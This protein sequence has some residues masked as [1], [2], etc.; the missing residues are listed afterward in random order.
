MTSRALRALVPAILS[1]LVTL[2]IAVAPAHAASGRFTALVVSMDPATASGDTTVTLGV[3]LANSTADAVTGI[4][5]RFLISNAPLQGRSEIP[6]AASGR[7]VPTFRT[8]STAVASG[9]DLTSGASTTLRLRTTTRALG[10][11]GTQS[12]VY[13]IGA[14]INGTTPAGPVSLRAVTLLPWMSGRATGSLGVAAFWTLTAPPSRDL[15]GVFIDDSLARAVEP[16]GR[17]RAQLD[18]IDAMQHTTL[19][20]DPLLVES[21]HSLA[22]GA[23]IR[24]DSGDVRATTDAEMRAAQQWLTDL[25]AATAQNALAALPVGDLDVAAALRYGRL[26]VARHALANA[27]QRLASALGV[28]RMPLI[29]PVHGGALPDSLWRTIA[30]FGATAVLAPGAGYPATQQR[31]TPSSAL[32]LPALGRP[33]LVVDAAASEAPV[34]PGL[35]AVQARQ[36][37]ASHLL[38]AYLEHPNDDR[39]IA[40]SV[41]PTWVPEA[42]GTDTAV[43]S[44]DW[45][46]LLGLERAAAYTPA[47][48][49]THTVPMT[50][51]Q[52]VQNTRASVA[53]SRQHTLQLLTSDVPF[54]SAV[55]DG[56]VGLLSRWYTAR[57]DATGYVSRVIDEL[58]TYADSVRVVTRGEIV[59][60]G[61]R[62]SVPVTIA[63]GLPVP[64]SIGLQASGIPS[65]RVQPLHYTPV[66]IN[67]GKRVSVEV[68]TRV[69]GSGDAY[70]LLQVVAGDR[71]PVGSASL[72]TVR[73]AAYAR[74][75]AYVVAVAFAALLLLI[76]TNTVRRIRSRSLG[77]DDHE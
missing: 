2:P 77:L 20:V 19:L 12:G 9:I 46:R 70:L 34:T 3:E 45:I 16:G 58:S 49:G 69:T 32:S 67:A 53:V 72:V 42:A 31:Y 4:S 52:R 54:A 63:N 64:V 13:T 21:L 40:I 24:L 55:D 25:G 14:I 11:H 59:F 18:A 15:D 47:A 38:M 29:V 71:V 26:G 17:L 51:T 33:A 57:V 56:V 30:S 62:G 27:A 7:L 48:R 73:S 61:E 68:P 28:P 23:R 35:D 50:G 8:L 39:A 75:A 22:S 10:L 76:A 6:D 37:F 36:A 66:R 43:L 44:S 65:V 1:V 5:A 74:V 41:P 60:G